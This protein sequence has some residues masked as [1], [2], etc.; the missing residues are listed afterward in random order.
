MKTK[1]FLALF[2][3]LV[4]VMPIYTSSNLEQPLA[5]NKTTEKDSPSNWIKESQIKVYNNKVII[6]IEG[7]EWAKFTD[8][9]SMD[10]VLD[11]TSNAIEIVPTSHEQINKGDIISYKVEEIEGTII[12]RVIET[13][14]DENG[15]FAITKGDNL[16]KADPFKIRFENI[17]RVVV[18]VIY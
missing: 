6:E 15:W 14:F 3:L 10:P 8:T 7:A 5:I 12:H 11:E 9:N 18:A 2:V 17:K 1:I 4:L 13:G 16:E